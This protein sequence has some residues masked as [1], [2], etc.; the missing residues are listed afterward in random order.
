MRRGE[1]IHPV[2]VT[3]A[4]NPIP[5]VGDALTVQSEAALQT[6]Q[7]DA[8]CGVEIDLHVR[9]FTTPNPGHSHTGTTAKSPASGRTNMPKYTPLDSRGSPS[10]ATPSI[11]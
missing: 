8:T 5:A 11:G 6:A 1:Q 7:V 2:L 3:A 9:H 4:R 10:T